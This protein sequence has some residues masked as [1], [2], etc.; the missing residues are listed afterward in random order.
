MVARIIFVEVLIQ[1]AVALVFGSGAALPVCMRLA[2]K[3]L[4]LSSI[5]DDITI[6]GAAMDPVWFG[7][8]SPAVFLAPAAII[9]SSTLCASI[10]P[11]LKAALIRPVE[12]LART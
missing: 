1:S 5:V 12:A 10:Y 9:L 2:E 11:G 4:D 6:G 8:I 3:G 7:V